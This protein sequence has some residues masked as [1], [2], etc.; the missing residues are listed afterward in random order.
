MRRPLSP[1]E[2]SREVV[3]T[4]VTSTVTH[5]GEDVPAYSWRL[6]VWDYVNPNAETWETVGTWQG[7][8]EAKRIA[9]A[10]WSSY[11]CEFWIDSASIPLLVELEGYHNI[12]HAWGYLDAMKEATLHVGDDIDGEAWAIVTMREVGRENEEV[13]NWQ[14]RTL[15]DTPDFC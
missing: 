2:P 9:I 8:S 3:L 7:W 10:S 13:Y 1:M 6:Y 4:C 14:G 15:L 5:E 12:H 11:R